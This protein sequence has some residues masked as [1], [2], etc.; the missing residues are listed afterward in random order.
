MVRR[1]EEK[2]AEPKPVEPRVLPPMERLTVAQQRIAVGGHILMLTH[3]DKVLW[4]AEGYTKFDLINHYFRV[5]EFI[6]PHLDGRP[7]SLKRYPDGVDAA[8]FFQKNAAPETPGWIPRQR[9]PHEDT[10]EPV[11]YIICNELATMLYLANL[12]CISQNPWLSALPH[13]E[14]PD[15]VA[16]DL[17][18]S[19]PEAFDECIEVALL[20][21]RQLERFG[22]VG[23]PKTSGA[24]G[25]HV[26]VPFEP[27][28]SFEQG[29]RFAQIIAMLCREERPDLITLE[30]SV[31]KRGSKL[32]L[33]YLQN[34]RGKTLA[35]VYS[36]R[37]RPGAT[38]STPLEWDE[39]KPGLRPGDFNMENTAERLEQRGD[40]FQGVLTARQDLEAALK[41]GSDILK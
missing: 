2:P 37:A 40:L 7:L 34:I 11:D 16:I 38:V 28:Y 22:L 15:I 12:A 21:R 6:V 23:Y 20:V 29:R 36:L 30:S 31:E 19:D 33:D 39:L 14:K 10:G 32:Y 25:I 17:D 41:K 8:F 5:S 4:P 18:P 13:L 3:L 9:I 1:K 27:R 24:T 35:S 26:Y